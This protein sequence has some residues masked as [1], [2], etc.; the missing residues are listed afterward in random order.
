LNALGD[1]A[2]SV[3]GIRLFFRARRRRTSRSAG[4]ACTSLAGSHGIFGASC[5][6]DG[7]YAK[8][9]PWTDSPNVVHPRLQNPDLRPSG[10]RSPGSG[11]RRSARVS[12][13]AAMGPL[14]P[15]GSLILVPGAPGAGMERPP[16]F[17]RE[18][19]LAPRASPGRRGFTAGPLRARQL[20]AWA[21][22]HRR[23]A[24]L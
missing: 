7:L 1:R 12:V 11:S 16:S 22:L 20:G 4:P 6:G 8:L 19:T 21:P 23:N 2:G 24:A 5:D 3:H 9:G 15:S 13:H 17:S 18:G 14:G 10:F